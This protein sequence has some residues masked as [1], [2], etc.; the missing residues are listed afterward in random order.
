LP[1]FNANLNCQKQLLYRDILIEDK[2]VVSDH[3]GN[4]PYFQLITIQNRNGAILSEKYYQNPFAKE[5][6][7]KGIKYN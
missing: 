3:F 4:A 2:Q 7:G 5:E 6:K 1:E